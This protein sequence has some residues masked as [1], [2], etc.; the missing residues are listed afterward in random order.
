MGIL[1]N[2]DSAG[3]SVSAQTT[4]PGRLII[5]LRRESSLPTKKEAERTVTGQIYDV[6][7]HPMI[8]R[9]PNYQQQ[10]TFLPMSRSGQCFGRWLQDCFWRW[11]IPKPRGFFRFAQASSWAAVTHV[12]FS[13]HK[14]PSKQSPLPSGHFTAVAQANVCIPHGFYG[15]IGPE[16][17]PRVIDR[18]R[19]AFRW[20]DRSRQFRLLSSAI[21]RLPVLSPLG[22]TQSSKGVGICS[23]QYDSLN[24]TSDNRSPS[25]GIHTQVKGVAITEIAM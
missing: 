22:T 5:N 21:L 13:L 11:S 6:R 23:A 15:M 9:L 12:F 4:L 8:V 16:N 18:L 19:L 20:R 1:S 24:L 2:D 7:I 14:T 10:C 3:T 25:R 17:I